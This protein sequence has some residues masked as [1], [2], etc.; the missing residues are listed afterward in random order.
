LRAA[1]AAVLFLGPALILSAAESAGESETEY[2][3]GIETWRAERESRLTSEY[4]WLSVAGLMWLMEG[5]VTLGSDPASDFV[6]P[7][8]APPRA[9]VI[10]RKG[11][12]VTVRAADGVDITLEGH[13]MSNPLVM[14][15]DGAAL[16]L[17]RLRMQ[18]IRRGDRLGLRLRDPDSKNRREF[19]GLRWFPVEPRYRIEARFHAYAAP[20]P[21]RIE[22]VLGQSSEDMSPGYAQFDLGGKTIRLHPVYEDGDTSRLFFVFKDKTAPS[23][24]Y[25][26]GRT[27][28]ADPPRNGRVV[29]DFNKAYNPPCAFSAYTTCPVPPKM[30]RMPVAVNAG[31]LKYGEK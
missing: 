23:Q 19:K 21:L 4:G 25:G 15:P 6:L 28:Y 7:P 20:Q 14:M 10:E 16:E 3:A 24:T 1:L 13:P 27:L 11:D 26:G 2:R 18:L 5:R 12:Q 30:N 17:G 22:N 29:L 8:S 9:G 31:E